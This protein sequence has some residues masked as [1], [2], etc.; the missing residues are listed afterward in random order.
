MARVQKSGTRPELVVRRLVRALG[1]AYRLNR[2]DVPGTP[3]LAFVGRRK[4]IFVHGCFW[5]RHGCKLTA[6]VPRTRAEYWGPK[7]TKNVAR[8]KL[9]IDSLHAMGWRTMI[10]WECEVGDL[11]LST[12]LENFLLDQ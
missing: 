7:F 3:D 10:V 2:Q 9:A 6:P 11:Q 5:H 4:A 8:D 1:L 12:R